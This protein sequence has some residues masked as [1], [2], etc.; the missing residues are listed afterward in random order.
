MRKTR[1]TASEAPPY[2]LL[3]V[4][5]ATE[6]PPEPEEYWENLLARTNPKVKVPDFTDPGSPGAPTMR[7]RLTKRRS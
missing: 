2:G 5:D 7:R 4:C 6:Q 3:P 1:S